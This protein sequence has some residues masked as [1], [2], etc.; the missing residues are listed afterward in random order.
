MENILSRFL[1][2]SHIEPI[3]FITCMVDVLSILLWKKLKG[4]MPDWQRALY[5]AII[6]V[7]VVL[8]AAVT[9]RYFG[10]IKDWKEL[11]SFWRF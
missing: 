11:K 4:G 10:F 5:K 6:L 7:A 3:Y 8:T 2:S 9:C 1:E